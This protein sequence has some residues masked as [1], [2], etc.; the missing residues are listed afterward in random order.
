LS[1]CGEN[2]GGKSTEEEGFTSS[3]GFKERRK[4]YS[5]LKFFNICKGAMLRKRVKTICKMQDK[6]KIEFGNL[7]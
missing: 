2:F 3:R 4:T 1:T 6:K 5:N 7:G